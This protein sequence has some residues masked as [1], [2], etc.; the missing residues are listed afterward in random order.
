[1]SNVHNGKPF[2][3]V[4]WLLKFVSDSVRSNVKANRKVLVRRRALYNRHNIFVFAWNKWEKY[5][6]QSYCL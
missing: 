3:S 1:M 2:V 5:A 4:L 6:F